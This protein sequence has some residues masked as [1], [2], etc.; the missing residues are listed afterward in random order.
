MRQRKRIW[1]TGEAGLQRG[2]TRQDEDSPSFEDFVRG[3]REELA[4]WA[5]TRR[6]RRQSGRHGSPETPRRSD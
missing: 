5:E 2:P 1:E 4:K 3:R 6:S